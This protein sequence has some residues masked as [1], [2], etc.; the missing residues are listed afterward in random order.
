MVRIL[1]FLHTSRCD[2]RPIADPS[3]KCNTGGSYISNSIPNMAK[4]LKWNHP[5]RRMSHSQNEGA[6]TDALKRLFCCSVFCSEWTFCQTQNLWDSVCSVSFRQHLLD[7]EDLS[8]EKIPVFVSFCFH[9]MSRQ[10][11]SLHISRPWNI[12]THIMMVNALKKERNRIYH[13]TTILTWYFKSE[14]RG[15]FS[16]RKLT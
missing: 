4:P 15:N 7:V 8:V 14:V 9:S 10:H 5:Q 1:C 2:N 13:Q 3:K 11:L 6:K 12:L 16:M